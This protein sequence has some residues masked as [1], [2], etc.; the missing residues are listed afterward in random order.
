MF[1]TSLNQ[2]STTYAA[3]VI[4]GVGLTGIVGDLWGSDGK[5]PSRA[6]EHN[7]GEA[8]RPERARAF[9]MSIAIAPG[10]RAD[11]GPSERVLSWCYYE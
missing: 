4:L 1:P 11:A 6:K 10:D 3:P 7:P 9:G 5:L 2:C 8:A